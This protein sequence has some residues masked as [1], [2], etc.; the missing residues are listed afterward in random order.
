MRIHHL[1]CTTMCPPGGRLVD[2]R[3]GFTGPAALT[4]HCLLVEGRQ[5]LI[6]VDTG[7]GLEDVKHR[8]PRL[9]PLFLDLLTRPQ[10]N[11]GA[12]AVRQIERMGFQ[13]KDVRDIVLTH[14]DFDHAGGLDDF[15][16]ARVHLLSDEYQGAVAQATPLDRRRYRPLQWMHE[17]QWVMYPSGGDGER[18]FGFEC[19]RDLAGLPPEI[20]LVPLPGHTLGHAGVAI[21]NGGGWL[22]HAGDAYFYHG[23]MAPDRY[24]CTP[25]LRAYQKLMQK[26]GYLRWHNMRRLRELVQRHGRDVTVFCAH[27]SLEFELLEEQEK[28]PER[29]PLRTFVDTRPPLHA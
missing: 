19:V 14:L 23:E 8:R 15:P 22:L 26:D 2:G 6:L 13:A 28:A 16:H 7:F 10:L 5:G 4:C 1:N 9:S 3:K 27:D 20:L 12:T 24:R 11:E 29:S 18:W 21:Q 25:G 17:A